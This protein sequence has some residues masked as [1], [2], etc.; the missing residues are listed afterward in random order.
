MKL[1]Y[2]DLGAGRTVLLLHG[3]AGPRSVLP[4]AHRLAGRARVIVPT[5]PGFDGTPGGPDGVGD[6]AERYLALLDEL[7]LRGVAVVGNSIGGWIA[8]EMAVRDTARRLDRLV[9]VGAVG[10][11]VPE[12]P[13][14]DFFAL[15]F[16]EL[17]RRSY[18]NPDAFRIDPAALT[19][20]QRDTMAG[21]RRAIAH[22]SGPHGMADPG[23]RAR[24]GD[25]AVPTLALWGE[26]DRIVDPDYGR[27]YAAAIPGAV[28]QL[29]PGTGHIPLIE[30]PDQVLEVFD[31]HL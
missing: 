6:L 30:T 13:V 15:D 4:F 5:H 11:A 23:L 21:N 10:I 24:L 16:D 8:A 27:A 7:G 17:A 2:D 20:A 1:T 9:L 22:Y 18:A 25:V 12:H 26:S 14:A 28:F 29:L 31:R 3:G 19:D